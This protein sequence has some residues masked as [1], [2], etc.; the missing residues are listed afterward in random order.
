MIFLL[1]LF[2]LFPSPKKHY[3]FSEKTIQA[4]LSY[5]PRWDG[6]PQTDEEIKETEAALSQSYRFLGGG[7]QCFSFAS[8]DG[9]YVIK[10]FKQK[11]IQKPQAKRERVFSA[12]QMSFDRLP[13][14]TGIFYIH[15]NPTGHLHKT[16]AFC[17]PDGKEHLLNL[18][19]LQF[20]IQKRATLAIHRLEELM[21]K[22]DFGQ[23]QTGYRSIALPLAQPASKRDL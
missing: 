20:V 13:A 21:A 12:F 7:G 17:D 14:E 23:G 22:R 9:K 10:F 1:V 2:L 8:Q 15:L 4:H 16:L 5:Q 6:R 3:P 18:D 19:G 11:K